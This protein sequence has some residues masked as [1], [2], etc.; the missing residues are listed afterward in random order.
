MNP[1]LSTV[2]VICR[3]HAEYDQNKNHVGDSCQTTTSKRSHTP[4][5]AEYAAHR[6]PNITRHARSAVYTF[7][8]RLIC[9]QVSF[10]GRWFRDTGHAEHAMTDKY[11]E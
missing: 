7:M 11:E 9:M 5:E 1:P 2:E 10:L 8:L 6:W 3:K 4:G